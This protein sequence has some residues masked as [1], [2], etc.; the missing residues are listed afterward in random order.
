MQRP[1][2][3]IVHAR[4]LVHRLW[5]DVRGGTA[6]EY[7]LILAFMVLMMFVALTQMADVAQG[8]WTDISSRVTKAR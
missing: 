4:A 7:G 6:I 2:S 5:G 1:P 3:V 8:M